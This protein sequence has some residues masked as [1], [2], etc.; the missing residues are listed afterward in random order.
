MKKIAILHFAY[1]PNIGGVESM[2]KEHA[3]ILTDL[4]YEITVITGSGEEKDPR[5]KLVVIPELQSIFNFDPF[6]QEKILKKGMIDSDC[7]KLA[8]I[9][10]QGLERTLEK[11]DVVVVHNMIT[12]VRNLAFVCAFKNFVKKHPKKKYFGWIHDHSY[13]DEFKIKDLDKVVNS[14]LEKD[15]LTTPIKNL[16]YILISESFR[17]PFVHLMN[18]H[19]GETVVIPN[20]IDVKHFLEIDN[21]IWEIIEKYELIKSFPLILSPVNIM[22][23]K[24]LEYCLDVISSLKFNFPKIKYMIT[25][26]PSK[27]HST[28]KYY[29]NLK[30]K[31]IDL[32]LKNNVIFLNDFLY[33]ALVRSEVH[34]LYQISDLVFFLSKS[35]NFGLPL[36][37]SSLTK[38]PIFVSDLKVFREV[39]GD[40]VRYLKYRTV[41][42]EK[43]ATEVKTFLEKSYRVQMNFRVRSQFDLKTILKE[44]FIPLLE[45]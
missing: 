12:I 22:D 1:P 35:E 17:E 7:Y 14:K 26:N 43:A 8:N 23:R 24:N 30:K 5:I 2:I 42:P 15:I 3:E 4:G 27:H 40:F 41:S 11:M 44:K 18:L 10:E 6:L 25:G 29:D 37:E 13:I 39:G 20:G 38:T 21:L 28:V 36:L 33:R 16:T 45:K 34:D 9:I 19:D 31:V 32:G